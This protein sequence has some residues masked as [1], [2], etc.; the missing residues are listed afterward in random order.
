MPPRS[1]WRWQLP[2]PL[3]DLF[4]EDDRLSSGAPLHPKWFAVAFLAST[5]L[6]VV[7]AT[8][9]CIALA[10]HEGTSINRM[11]RRGLHLNISTDGALVALSPIF[12]VVAQR[13]P[14]AAAAHRRH[15]RV[16]LPQH[17]VGP[18]PRARGP[19]TTS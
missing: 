11:L 7:N 1:R 10:L 18:R 12:A 15:R 9:T 8:L 2:S 5:A 6:F 17:E 13:S 4:H 16:R 19:T 3:L 14:A